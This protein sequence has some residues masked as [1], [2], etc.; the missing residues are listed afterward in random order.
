MD[1]NPGT[2]IKPS[3]QYLELSKWLKQFATA[4]KTDYLKPFKFLS[5][6]KVPIS[7]QTTFW[8]ET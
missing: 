8:W 1:N 4:P 7:V 6:N 5:N 2:F 3:P